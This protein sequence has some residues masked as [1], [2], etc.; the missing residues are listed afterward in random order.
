[1]VDRAALGRSWRK[2]TARYG[3]VSTA[4]FGLVRRKQ[5]EA[6]RDLVR[7]VMAVGRPSMLG[8]N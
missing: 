8:W 4:V 5:A 3:F 7:S 1:M 6:G 2:T